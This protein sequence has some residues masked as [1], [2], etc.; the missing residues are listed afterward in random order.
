MTL[1]N[2]KNVVIYGT[3]GP[4]GG[5]V[6]H[7]FA[8]ELSPKAFLTGRLLASVDKIAKNILAASRVAEA[9]EVEVHA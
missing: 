7:A 2:N 6:A 4:V 3:G 5:V 8:S 1:K 9:T